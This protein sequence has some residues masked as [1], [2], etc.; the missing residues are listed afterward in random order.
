MN[1]LTKSAF[2]ILS[3]PEDHSETPEVFQTAWAEL[4]AQR[5]QDMRTSNLPGSLHDVRPSRSIIETVREIAHRKGYKLARP[6][7]VP[8]DRRA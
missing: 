6:R 4:K 5:G 3:T 2:R 7:P 1:D 8:G